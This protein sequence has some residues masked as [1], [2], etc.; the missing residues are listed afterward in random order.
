MKPYSIFFLSCLLSAFMFSCK[1]VKTTNEYL[2]EVLTNLQE[3]KSASYYIEAEGWQHGDSVAMLT[4]CMYYNEYDNP[5]DTTI[6]ASFVSFAGDDTTKFNFG[7]NGIIEAHVYYDK[8]GVIVNDFTV[9]DLP[10][11]PVSPPFFNYT[12]NIINYILTTKDS[13][14]IE[15]I[16]SGEYYYLKL[17]INEDKQVEF[18]GKAHYMP[19]PPFY[20][21]EPT[22]IYELWI[23][24]TTNLPYKVRREMSH[25]ISVTTCY[26]AEIN[27]LSIDSFN[28]YAYFPQDYEVRK[29]T[30]NNEKRTAPEML[31]KAAPHWVLKDL[32]EQEVSLSDI[33]SK[34]LLINFTG[35]GCGPCY[36]AIPVLKE[37][38]N[39]Y[40]NTDF[41]LV[42]IESWV[43]KPQSLQNYTRKNNL[44]YKLLSAT[45]EVLKDYKTGGAAPVFVILDE[46]RIVRNVFNGYSQETTGKEI[47]EA[48]KKLL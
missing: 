37:L 27:K 26:D 11:R 15:P 46:N 41:E 18:F 7:Y 33:K 12:K 24:K 23:S 35:I 14:Q 47:K 13:I 2:N 20:M 40:N 4:Y 32:H 10:F 36:A 45:D 28:I 9:R 39:K 30:L 29:Y 1:H 3:I 48:I 17:I 42:G 22:S 44:N 43:R 8:K 34:V 21:G 6:G 31:G 19:E 38:K 16:D 25:D 5:N